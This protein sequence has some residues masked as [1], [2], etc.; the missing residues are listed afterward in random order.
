M[1]K[2][3]PREMTGAELKSML[4][5]SI[6]F[7]SL[8]GLKSP[9]LKL[10]P[11]DLT[12]W[13]DAKIGMFFHWGLYSILGRGEWARFNEQIPKDEYEALAEEFNPKD[14][15]MKELT[16]L[17]K[18][19]GAKYM[20]MV[21]RHH[22]GFALWD[23]PGSYEGFTSYNTGSK[24][25]FVKEYTE[26]CR[27]D[28]LKVGVYYSPMDWRFPG[29]FDPEGLPDNAL[30][31]KK[32]CYDQVRELCSNYG[33]ID[34]MWYDGGWLA[35]KGSDTSSAW[36]WEPIKLNKI[37][38]EYNPKTI[39]NPRSGWEG[40]FYCDEGSHEIKGGIIPVPWEKNMCVCS[41]SSWG[42]M[43]ED[44]V[45]DFD[46]L[47]QMMV[48]VVCRDGNWLVNVAPD[49]NGKLSEEVTSR[50]REIGQWLAKNGESIYSTRGGPMEP[51]DGVYG[52]TY[53]ENNI[54][55]HVLDRQ[56]F[57]KLSLP[58][59][60]HKILSCETL[61]GV[62]CFF[63]QNTNQVKIELPNLPEAPDYIIKLTLDAK[64]EKNED[65]QIYFTGKE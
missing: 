20:V 44:P 36:F 21:T 51:V 34:I 62:S 9:E 18:D 14:F 11:E 38:R 39:I 54:Y 45:S 43:A 55:L 60:T 26:A 47:I 6:N 58:G 63:T 31:M 50:I 57:A 22:D 64:V 48:N 52:T 30:L 29:Y 40:D 56:A 16:G 1:D 24:R 3:Q 4:K 61:D 2:K 25:D 17:A 15:S 53:R 32:Q 37:V 19:F 10:S 5:S 42:W 33:Q 46:W 23:S 59:I 65:S 28:G 12:W 8:G 27:E 35:H 49:K 41:G 13:R 7:K